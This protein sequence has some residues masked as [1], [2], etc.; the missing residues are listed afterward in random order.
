MGSAPSRTAYA[1]VSKL[2]VTS[3][4][5]GIAQH[6][7]SFSRFFEFIFRFLVARILVGMVFECHL[8][9]GLLYITLVGVFA[10]SQYLVVI[11]FCHFY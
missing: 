3:A 10:N 5:V 2:V 9:I 7:V 6:F 4:F 11:S 8:A 1:L